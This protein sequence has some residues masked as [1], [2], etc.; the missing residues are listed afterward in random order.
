LFELKNIK[1]EGILRIDDL[2]IPSQTF[3][4]LLGPSGCG[5]S[6]LLRLLNVLSSPDEGSIFFN[7]KPIA[8]LN[9]LEFRRSVMMVPQSP[10]I[11]DGSIENNLQIGR[12]FAEKEAASRSE[13]EKTLEMFLLGKQ[14]H[15]EA[16]HLSG[17]EKQRLS[18]ARAMLL[19]PEV[20]LLDEPTS[21]LDENTAETVL[22]RFY[23][24]A[25]TQ[26]KTVIMVTHSTELVHLVGE[27]TIDMSAYSL[28]RRLD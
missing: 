24:Y 22:K 12:Q 8:N 20:F 10:V 16:A 6:T 23:E 15:E 9:P 19:D 27:N 26:R 17:G 3:T 18:W 25:K 2:T 14:L 7:E 5:K 28:Q 1:V 11:F 4:I 21:A 13:M